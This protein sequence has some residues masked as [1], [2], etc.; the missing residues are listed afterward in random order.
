MRDSRLPRGTW[1]AP[2]RWPSC[3]SSCSRTSSEERRVGRVEALVGVDRR[4]LVDLRLDL[5]Q[6]LSVGRH[7]FRE[8]SNGRARNRARPPRTTHRRSSSRLPSSFVSPAPASSPITALVA[9]LAAGFVV[10]I[11]ARSGGEP[12]PQTQAT[13][14]RGGAAAR[15]RSGFPHGRGGAGLAAGAA[16]LRGGEARS[17]GGDLL[18]L[19]L[20]RGAGRGDRLP[21]ARRDGLGPLAPGRALSEERARP[22]RARPRALL[23]GG[24]GRVGRVAAGGRARAR[25]VVRGRGRRISS[26]RSTRRTS[27]IFVPA[28]PRLLDGLGGK[29]PP[30]SSAS[31]ARWAADGVDGNRPIGHLLY[32]VALQR[33]DHPLSARRE[34]DRAAALAPGRPRGARRLRR[35][36]VRQGRPVRRVLAPRAARPPV[37]EVGDGALPSRPAPAS[38]SAPSHQAKKE[39]RLATTVATR[40]AARSGARPTC[41]LI[42]P[43]GRP[44]R[45]VATLAIF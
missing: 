19:R 12:P 3:H 21:L 31:C 13:P 10:A 34:F 8:Y 35:R 36:A 7:Y 27:P 16:A 44:C 25:H 24:A 20:D 42:A 14:R 39:L 4:D 18:A 40:L 43:C 33:L 37:P 26:I 17:G 2:G 1:R 38:G 22:A 45:D 11:A 30:S 23:G 29:P 6:D 32:G 9:A 5:R 15:A 41:T 28:G